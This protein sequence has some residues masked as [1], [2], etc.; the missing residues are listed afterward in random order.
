MNMQRQ[1]ERTTRKGCMPKINAFF[2]IRVSPCGSTGRS[3]CPP[4]RKKRTTTIPTTT[5]DNNRYNTNNNKPIITVVLL[6]PRQTFFE[7]M[8]RRKGTGRE[9]VCW[10][11]P[12]KLIVWGCYS[13]EWAE[14]EPYVGEYTKV[15][16][17][18]APKTKTNDNSKL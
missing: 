10:C 2:F 18:G 5:T 15:E 11:G 12:K 8:P 13:K 14:A 3:R 17:K 9:W 7:P 6:C 16:Y 4:R 1:N